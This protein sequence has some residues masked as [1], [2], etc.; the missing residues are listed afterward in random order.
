MV[1]RRMTPMRAIQSGTS[2][3]TDHMGLGAS[4]GQLLKGFNA[5]IIAV[6]NNPLA[7]IDTLHKVPIASNKGRDVKKP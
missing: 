3:A 7:N 2:V 4:L 5:D 6:A 1:Q